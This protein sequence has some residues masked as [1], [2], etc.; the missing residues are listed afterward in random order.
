MAF[1]Q[2]K[3]NYTGLHKRPT[4]EGLINYLQNEQETI[5]FPNRAAKQARNHPYLTQ[6]DGDDYAHMTE[7]Q[8][9]IL[10]TKMNED[11][12]NEQ[13]GGPS[14]PGTNILRVQNT[15]PRYAVSDPGATGGAGVFSQMSTP[16][17]NIS[18]RPEVFSMSRSSSDASIFPNYDIFGSIQEQE[19]EHTQTQQ[20][21]EETDREQ[22]KRLKHIA[23]RGLQTLT[24][25]DIN[26]A[27]MNERREREELT[28]KKELNE[29]KKTAL[30]KL[31][32]DP[33]DITQH[34]LKIREGEIQSSTDKKEPLFYPD[35]KPPPDKT[36][37]VIK[38]WVSK[39]KNKRST[40]EANLQEQGF[41]P[42]DYASFTNE[43][44]IELWLS[45]FSKKSIT[46]YK[47]SIGF[48]SKSGAASSS[49]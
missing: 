7:Q 48:I 23:L 3:V 10:R 24:K 4:Y 26:D 47:E 5:Q 19:T 21:L 44:A 32:R 6:L 12:L 39:M 20:Q 29:L 16:R 2:Y 14:G 28:K 38:Y 17:P 11:R 30:F 13:A 27:L 25:E 31:T 34:L 37:N 41:L 45:K 49:K 35:Q 36:T 15:R 9:S 42:N 8:L 18:M 46:K 33:D 40:I 22:K 43:K 1:N